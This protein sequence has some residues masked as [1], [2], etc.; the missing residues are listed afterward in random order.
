MLNVK[1]T[2]DRELIAKLSSMPAKLREALYRKTVA[3]TLQ[4]E[5]KVK[6]KLSGV[7]LNVV[8]GALRR[9]I[10]RDVTQGADFVRGK[11][12]S[13]GDVKYA[14]IHEFGGVIKHP[15]GTKYMMVEGKTIFVSKVLSNNLNLPVTKPH[16]IPMP[17]RSYMR[18]SLREMAPAIQQGYRDTVLAT[19]RGN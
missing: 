14:G 6:A 17:E 13:A 16:N 4:L 2:G 8:S 10:Q 7:V 18:S 5:A 11:V 3:F 9:S 12:Y 19:L 15:G 1:F